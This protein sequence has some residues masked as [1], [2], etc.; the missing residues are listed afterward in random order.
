MAQSRPSSG[1][2]YP[3]ALRTWIYQEGYTMREVARELAIPI[4]TLRHWVAGDFS[5]PH[6]ER[7]RLARFF[8]CSVQ[9]LIPPSAEPAVPVT[10]SDVVLDASSL[11][12][13]ASSPLYATGYLHGMLAMLFLLQVQPSPFLNP[14]TS[15]QEI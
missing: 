13:L 1:P 4:G 11:L 5:I 7:E 14:S 3:N 12:A 8:G 10:G 9:D 2:R 6:C 15:E